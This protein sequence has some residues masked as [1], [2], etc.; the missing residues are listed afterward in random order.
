MQ[1]LNYDLLLFKDLWVGLINVGVSL[2]SKNLC[3]HPL[4]YDG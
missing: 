3:E 4:W 1:N 2:Y